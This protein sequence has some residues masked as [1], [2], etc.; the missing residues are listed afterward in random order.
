MIVPTPLVKNQEENQN[1][2]LRQISLQ[3]QIELQDQEMK[4]IE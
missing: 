4:K 1:W 3:L 2:P